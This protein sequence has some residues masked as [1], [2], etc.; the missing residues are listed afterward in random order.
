MD[1]GDQVFFANFWPSA[2]SPIPASQTAAGTLFSYT[3]E[4]TD[5][6]E[7]G[8][9]NMEGYAGFNTWGN[10]GTYTFDITVR[11]PHD[12]DAAFTDP[13]LHETY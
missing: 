1:C 3:L 8:T 13:S 6:S 12:F 10:P 4:S 5:V 7:V 2:A 9:T 11:Q